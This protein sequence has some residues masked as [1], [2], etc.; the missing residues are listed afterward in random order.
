MDVEWDPINTHNTDP[1]PILRTAFQ[2]IEHYPQSGEVTRDGAIPFPSLSVYTGEAGELFPTQRQG[3]PYTSDILSIHK[4]ANRKSKYVI[5]SEGEQPAYINT[6]DE[7]LDMIKHTFITNVELFMTSRM[8]VDLYVCID[9]DCL[10]IKNHAAKLIQSGFRNSRKYNLRLD[11]P[12]EKWKRGEFYEK[13]PENVK[14]SPEEQKKLWYKNSQIDKKMFQMI[15]QGL[16]D[17]RKNRPIRDYHQYVPLRPKDR[18]R[19]DPYFNGMTFAKGSAKM[20][21][22]VSKLISLTKKPGSSFKIKVM[23]MGRE[24]LE[25]MLT[26][27]HDTFNARML[28]ADGSYTPI[29][30]DNHYPHIKAVLYDFRYDTIREISDLVGPG[31]SFGRKGVHFKL[32]QLNKIIKYLSSL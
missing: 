1:I 29:D 20:K 3:K 4:N 12:Y 22:F 16:V 19:I 27:E 18:V 28:H 9:A 26:F 5:F 21:D 25:F 14:L 30:D 11:E 23:T 6:V 8:K 17:T 10:P 13:P 31:S 24:D 32:P 15:E 2:M 7:F